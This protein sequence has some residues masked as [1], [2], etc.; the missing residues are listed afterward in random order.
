MRIWHKFELSPEIWS[1][2]KLEVGTMPGIFLFALMLCGLLLPSWN[3]N[4]YARAGYASW[5]K[6]G[7]VYVI[8]G[9]FGDINRTFNVKVVW[10]GNGFVINT[11]L[12]A[13]RLKRR[14]KT[15]T[16]KVYFQKAWAH[17]TWNRSR[18]YVSYKGLRGK[19]SVRKVRNKAAPKRKSNFSSS[20]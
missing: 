17:V 10:K 8:D 6:H 15:V 19:A 2:G 18:A 13:Y 9:N 16:F 20:N 14:G 4:A 12:G 1:I 5:V 3:N 11:P 7:D